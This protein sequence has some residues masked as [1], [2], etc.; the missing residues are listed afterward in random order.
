MT[1]HQEA[2]AT[3]WWQVGCSQFLCIVPKIQLK[4][5]EVLEHKFQL[6]WFYSYA[7]QQFEPLKQKLRSSV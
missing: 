7:L 3:G 4:I 1:S 5:S 2:A 6:L